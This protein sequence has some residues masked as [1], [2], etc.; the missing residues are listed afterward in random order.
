MRVPGRD[1]PA[2]HATTRRVVDHGT[3][4]VRCDEIRAGEVRAARAG[5][6]EIPAEQNAA[7]QEEPGHYAEHD[8]DDRTA[9]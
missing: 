6:G 5:T 8:P 7:R 9:P 2:I 1:L 3:G 4:E